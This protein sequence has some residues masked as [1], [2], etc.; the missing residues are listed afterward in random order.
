MLLESALTELLVAKDYTPLTAIRRE[1][2]LREFLAWAAENGVTRTE[3]VTKALVRRYVAD[4]RTRPNRR[5]GDKLAGETQHSRAS[6]VR[7][8]LRW[9]AREGDLDA[10]V[11]SNLDM[12]RIPQKVVAVFTPEHYQRLV[13]AADRLPNQTMRLR[14]KAVLAILLDTGIRAEEMCGLTLENLHIGGSESYIRVVGKGRKEREV[15]LGK[16]AALAIQRYLSRARPKSEAPTVFLTH[17][18]KR[19]TPNAIDR[20]MHRLRDAAG[21]QFFEGIRVSAH[22]LRHSFAVHYLEQGGDLYKLSRL[23]G[24]ENVSTTTRYLRA[25]QARSARLGSH[26]VLDGLHARR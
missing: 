18:R 22:T 5:T 12:P 13:V 16:Q 20:V 7:M 17:A 21:Q 25:F 11:A 2:V 9:L 4:L 24:H 6:I 14:D 19:M 26:S 15:G 23:M 10:Q 1:D 3:E 8:F